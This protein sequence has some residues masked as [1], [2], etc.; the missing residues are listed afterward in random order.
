[1]K[2][3][4]LSLILSSFALLAI[5]QK[6]AFVDTKYILDNIPE[7]KEAQKELDQLSEKWQRDAEQKKR[8][9][10]NKI[11]DYQAEQVL[12]SADMRKKRE[13]EIQNL[14]EDLKTFQK[15]KFGVKGEL[16]KKRKELIEPIQNKVYKAI[17][18]LAKTSNYD[19]IFDKANQ[20]NIL[21][22]DSKYD[23]SK[24]ILKDLGY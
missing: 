6:Y 12:L 21:Y 14:Q 13:Q 2:K 22:A 10:D 1:M 7:F 20:T 16:Y 17:K 18:D 11:R 24:R 5:S 8:D 3:I 23:K 15:E 9:L 4:V 19:F